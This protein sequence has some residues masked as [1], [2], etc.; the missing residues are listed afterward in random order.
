MLTKEAFGKWFQS[1]IRQQW[2]RYEFTAVQL[3]DWY[4]RLKD[5]DEA[6]L[7]AATRRHHVRNEPR[8]PSLKAIY[9]YAQQL[10]TKH[11]HTHVGMA[12]DNGNQKP[13]G[14]PEPHTYIQCVSKDDNDRGPVGWFVPVLLWPFHKTYT[15]AVYDKTA[16]QQRTLYQHS[17]GGVW[18][19][20]THTT[21]SRMR[22]RQWKLT[23]QWSRI[24]QH[25]E[26]I[27]ANVDTFRA[28]L[29]TEADLNRGPVTLRDCLRETSRH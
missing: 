25:T 17:Y 9:D 10:N 16:E 28:K 15:Q 7:S 20:V 3:S 23:G 27:F 6:T 13:S 4:W 5:F 12:P 8:Q 1:Q 29:F 22:I 19:V 24:E 14:V 21:Y 18:E 11:A 2:P 26:K